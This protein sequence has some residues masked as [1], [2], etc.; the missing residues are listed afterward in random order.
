MLKKFNNIGWGDQFWYQKYGGLLRYT[1][2]LSY[3]AAEAGLNLTNSRLLYGVPLSHNRYLNPF[4]LIQIYTYKNLHQ[5][6]M[7]KK[8]NKS[9]VYASL[10]K[11]NIF[12]D[13]YYG[14]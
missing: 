9:D 10:F 4:Y 1:I 12:F 14:L 6:Y 8:W 7:A 2:Q 13:K 3:L 11:E 5:S